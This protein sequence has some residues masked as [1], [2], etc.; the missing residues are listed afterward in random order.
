MG[1]AAKNESI[2]P[3]FCEQLRFNFPEI[4]GVRYQCGQ[5]KVNLRQMPAQVND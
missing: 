3:S 4:E 2:S 1:G 5:P